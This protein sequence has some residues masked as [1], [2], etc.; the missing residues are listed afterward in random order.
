MREVTEF[1]RP[2]VGTGDARLGRVRSPWAEG[3]GEA[4]VPLAG[5]VS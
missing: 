3:G 2:M 4:V 5:F 1:F